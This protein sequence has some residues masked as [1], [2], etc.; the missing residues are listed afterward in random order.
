MGTP[1]PGFAIVCSDI[2]SL[3]KV[4]SGA[5]V[6]ALDERGRSPLHAAC[7]AAKKS[8]NHGAYRAVLFLLHSGAD[9]NFQDKLG[10]T[11][12]HFAA[13]SGR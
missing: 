11:P 6:N 1:H 9:I 8:D 3:S 13:L 12:L 5:D 10:M 7:Q 2:G 4:E